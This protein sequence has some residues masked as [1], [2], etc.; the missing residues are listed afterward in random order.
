MGGWV[1]QVPA[2]ICF[3]TCFKKQLL[4]RGWVDKVSPIRSFVNLT[5]HL[6]ALH[7]LKQHLLFNKINS[8]VLIENPACLKDNDVCV[9]R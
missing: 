2:R 7:R 8:K 9:K 6:S 1:V 5:R 4:D 3:C